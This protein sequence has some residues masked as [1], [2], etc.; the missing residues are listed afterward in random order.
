[1][2]KQGLPPSPK[3]QASSPMLGLYFGIFGAGLAAIVLVLLV[4]EQ[5]GWAETTIGRLMLAGPLALFVAVGAAGWTR[6]PAEFFHA[7][8]RVPAFFAG[9][10]LA[11]V[12]FGGAGLLSLSGALLLNGFDV[13][14][15]LLGIIAGFV[16]MAVAVAPFLRKFGAP[17]VPAY[18]GQRFESALVRI[19]AASVTAAALLLLA[20][21]EM[22][23]AA[24]AA[25]WLA[26]LGPGTT[27]AVVVAA[28]AITLAPGG[29]RSLTWSSAAQAIAAVVALLVPVAIVAVIMTNLPLPQVSHGP[30]LRGIARNEVQTAAAL[31][32]PPFAFDLPGDGLVGLS[33]RFA[34]PFTS[35]GPVAFVLA[36]LAVAAGIAASPVLLP[37][38]TTT[39]SVYET[40]KALGW[41]VFLAGTVILTFSAIAVFM[42]DLIASQLVG[43]PVER[44][45]EGLRDLAEMG[46][47]GI[48]GAS[49]RITAQ[50]LQLRRDGALLALPMLAGLPA[51]LA[52]LVAAGVVAASLAA[53]GA[54]LVQLAVVLADDV[55]MSLLPERPGYD[56]RMLAVR[57][58]LGGLVGLVGLVAWALPGDPLQ[59][60]LW[61]LALSGSALFPVLLLSIWWKRLTA[62]GAA[63]A[64]AS[65]VAVVLT[66][67]VA[68]ALD[69][70]GGAA[71]LA[72][73]AGV[74]AAI[75]AA[76][77]ASHLAPAPD[78][79]I[80]EMVRDLRIPGGEAISD[81]EARRE[82]QLQRSRKP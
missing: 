63:A 81:R 60:L 9:T 28:L 3:L 77:V 48:E 46:L 26:G 15:V 43:V 74:P 30:I 69:L 64:M 59:L 11:V 52:H 67:L 47:A 29:V 65:G 7:G 58:A 61:S 4:L 6:A 66:A 72:A 44:L 49:P 1:M 13:L 31:L 56:R 12:A 54:S 45:P 2:A 24:T 20:I 10:V 35:I 41:T 55:A 34:T 70:V 25:G 16:V 80:L 71:V 50:A 18:L 40:R 39:V 23:A 22:K 79:H 73:I 51:V 21:A 76:I 5:L 75:L 38:T 82:L 37:R 27:M 57:A 32:A 8:R 68:N 53:A 42:R 78:R 62:S 33:P 36:A 14:S 19:A 17:S